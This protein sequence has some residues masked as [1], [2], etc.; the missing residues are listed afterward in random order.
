MTGRTS[1]AMT[2]IRYREMP[3]AAKPEGLLVSLLLPLARV[4]EL[5]AVMMNGME[6]MTDRRM[7]R[8]ASTPAFPK[9]PAEA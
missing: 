2:R 8:S 3:K 6:A 4:A 5:P 7:V 1:S 9:S